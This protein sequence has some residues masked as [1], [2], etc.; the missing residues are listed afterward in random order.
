ME[1]ITLPPEL[2]RFA[3]EAVA[4]G[5]FQ[6]VSAVVTAGLSLLQHQE[7]ARADFVASLQEAEAEADRIGCVSLE[8][9]DAGM[10]EAIRAAATRGQ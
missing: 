8:Q 5:R 7:K 2:E 4:R 6:D 1:N 3:A 9:V 10:R